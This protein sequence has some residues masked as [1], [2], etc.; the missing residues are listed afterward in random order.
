MIPLFVLRLDTYRRKTNA[1]THVRQTTVMQTSKVVI[2]GSGGIEPEPAE[3]NRAGTEPA[4]PRRRFRPQE[5]EPAGTRT[6]WNWLWVPALV[7]A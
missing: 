7:P 3:P 1:K 4:E 2:A 5:V 6:G